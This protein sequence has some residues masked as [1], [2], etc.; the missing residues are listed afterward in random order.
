ML[1]G[2]TYDMGKDRVGVDIFPTNIVDNP[3]I[4]NKTFTETRHRFVESSKEAR[5]FLEVA[6]SFSLKV[7]AG[8][9]K[10]GASGYYLGNSQ[11]RE[12]GVEL[13]IK[14][15]YET[16]TETLPTDAV[17]K[18]DWKKNSDVLGTHYVRSITY[19]G[20]LI[21]SVLI[22]CKS[23][24]E[25]KHI[26]GA[27]DVGGRVAGW[28]DLEVEVEGEYMKDI[29]DMVDSMEVKYYSSI[30]VSFVPSSMKD[31]HQ[32]LDS[33]PD[34]L[35]K[36]NNGKGVPI[37]VE[38]SP[39]TSLDSHLPSFFKDS[40]LEGRMDTIENLLDDLLTTRDAFHNWLQG[41]NESLSEEQEETVGKF[42]DDLDY[43]IRKFYEVIAELDL[44]SS[45]EQLRPAINAY[46]KKVAIAT[47]HA[48][49]SSYLQL[50]QE[51]SK[52][53]PVHSWKPIKGTGDIYVH[54][55]GETCEGIWPEIVNHGFVFSSSGKSSGGVSNFICINENAS[56]GINGNDFDTPVIKKINFELYVN[57]NNS[58]DVV[59]KT[60]ITHC[61][62]CRLSA[63]GSVFTFPGY[64]QC[65]FH[66][67]PVYEGYLAGN[68]MKNN[69][70]CLNRKSV[71]GILNEDSITEKF[72]NVI[73]KKSEENYYVPCIVCSS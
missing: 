69:L 20:E 71:E 15:R 50:R 36:F 12:N 34:D 59:K 60:G 41:I 16:V 58:T 65:P 13:L 2:R 55:G 10:A 38:L 52:D 51:I 53:A 45:P 32:L 1:L 4:I 6:G 42:S 72:T 23:V 56:L 67:N 17:P 61:A 66:W 5:D 7:K 57:K 40:T 8:L 54:W 62:I 37:R 49:Y 48:Y 33:F 73:L 27:I 11:S 3:T 47:H 24:R 26:K 25:K 29:S 35:A 14:T 22:K 9:F 64:N 63:A 39:L 46:N 44:Q 30:P 18:P 70:I 21:V 28:L 31:L 43:V 19:G 68:G